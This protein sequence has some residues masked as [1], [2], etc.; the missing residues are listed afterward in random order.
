MFGQ[1]SA[2]AHLVSNRPQLQGSAPSQD[3]ASAQALVETLRQRKLQLVIAESLTGGA[4]SSAIVSAPGASKVLLG[5]IV[6]YDSRLKHNLLGVRQSSLDEFGAASQ[7]VAREMAHG[8]RNLA[9]EASASSS[10]S[11]V[12]VATTGVAGPE[13]QD[14]VPVGTVYVAIDGPKTFSEVLEFNFEGDRQSIREQTVQ[15]TLKALGNLL[16]E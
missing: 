1:L 13:I 11:I 10:G 16:H 2:V 14:G 3:S 9:A 7:Q 6:A 15:A 4:L 8:A 5:C 12:A